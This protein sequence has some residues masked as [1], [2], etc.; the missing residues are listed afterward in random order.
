[1]DKQRVSALLQ[2]PEGTKLD[3]K[4]QLSL[5]TDSEKK[6]LA[7]D[8]VAI[9]NS[10]GGRGYIVF[11]VEDKTARIVGID[12]KSYREEQIQQI[13]SQRCDPPVTINFDIVHIENKAVGVL[14]VYKSYQ[15]P[16]QIRQTGTFYIRRGS[17]T[18]FAR[19]EEI[20]SMFQES[21]LIQY[22][23][24]VVNNAE[25]YDLNKSH[26]DEYL[27]KVGMMYTDENYIDVLESIGAMGREEDCGKMH[28]TVGGLLVFGNEPQRF[29]PYAGIKLID[30]YTGQPNNYFK[31]SI[32]KM[33]DQVEG[34]IDSMVLNNDYPLEALME[35]VANAAVHRDY[36]ATNREI[37]ISLSAKKV[38]ISNP[39]ALSSEE[40]DV[41][42]F[43]ESNPFRRNPWLY[44]RLQ[45]L[46]NKNRFLKTGIGISNIRQA[47]RH[48]G[49]IKFSNNIKRN[50]FKIVLP[51]LE[52]SL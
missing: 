9:A 8:I 40:E 30:N 6:E 5:K 24:I 33:L 13:I 25:V 42:Y 34:Y 49:E 15:K 1:M 48:I 31:G 4:V 29:L 27:N 43:E 45:I 26:I 16:H 52:H 41:L 51:G 11:G 20:A 2:R 23:S 46:D 35:A 37:V 19:R 47:F 17:T 36:F 50:L 7:K 44:Q 22:E 21:G 32:T 3:F 39:G 14:T 28:P 12:E 38:E 18:D 10:K